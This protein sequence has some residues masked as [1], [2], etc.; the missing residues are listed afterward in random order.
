ME[1]KDLVQ[2]IAT[3]IQQHKIIVFY[4]SVQWRHIRAEVLSEQH[5]ECQSCKAKGLYEPATMVHH[6]EYVMKHPDLALTKSNLIAL[7]NE[8]HYQIHHAI[9]YKIQLNTEKW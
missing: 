4:K 8:C 3:L 1:T 5:G 6:K 2:W 7:C 9:K